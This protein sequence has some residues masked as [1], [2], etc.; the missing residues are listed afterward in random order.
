MD[1]KSVKE[2]IVAYFKVLLMNFIGGTEK[3]K[4]SLVPPPLIKD[5]SSSSLAVS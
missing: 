3:P 2:A 4:F 5:W 1:E